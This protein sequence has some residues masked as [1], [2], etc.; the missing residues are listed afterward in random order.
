MRTV[1]R[2]GRPLAVAG[3]AIVLLPLLSPDPREGQEIRTNTGH[4]TFAETAAPLGSVQVA[5]QGTGYGTAAGDDGRFQVTAP[6]RD[7]ALVVPLIGYK[8]REV[9]VPQ[10]QGSVIVQLRHD[11]LQLD[12]LVV[13]GR[14]TSV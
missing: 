5:V 6:D 7:V 2:L 9:E 3:A 11:V 12:E 14:V 8:T 13:S 10:G 4:F 1:L